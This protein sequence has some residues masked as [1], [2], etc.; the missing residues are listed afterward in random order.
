MSASVVSLAGAARDK[1]LLGATITW[2]PSQIE[3]LESLDGPAQLHLWAIARQTGKSS[4]AGAAA[5]ANAA[6]REDLD[7]MLPHGK[8]RSVPVIAPSESQ[9]KDF[10]QVCQ[11]L[12]EGSPAF[13][14]YAEVLSDRVLFRIPRVDEHG[15]RWTA[16]CAIRALPASAPSIRGLTAALVICE[17]MAHHGDT[18]GPAD[19]R[20]IWDAI[21]P[22]QVAFG[23]KAKVVGISTP[24]G[25][26][27]LFFELFTAI[28]G[29]LMPHAR[30]VRREIAEMIPDI[31]PVWL[32]ARRAEMGDTAFEQEFLA[33]FVGSG[34]AFF[35]LRGVEFEEAPFRPEDATSWVIGTDAAFHGDRFG[36]VL[37]GES[38]SEPGVFLVGSVAGIEPGERLRSLE[39]R[40]Q[41]EDATLQKVWEIVEPYRI[42][43]LKL[44][45]DQHQSDAISSYF[46][47]LGLPV[48]IINITS[49]IQTAAF[50][51]LRARLV[52]GSLRCWKHPLLLE[53]FR[54]VRVARTAE[55]IVLP[56]FAGGHCDAVSAL[57]L[58]CYSLR[59]GSQR[60][61]AART[62]SRGTVGE[63]YRPGKSGW[64]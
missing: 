62:T 11:A 60:P 27:G 23:S 58:A 10:I 45:G 39:S 49:P 8:W 31:D 33:R 40:R 48:E 44:V 38:A 2:R 22:M 25:E 13:A 51:S 52:D 24:F 32:E 15:H 37:V 42:R 43:P 19:E 26:N 1:R 56:R 30:A 54:R 5:V 47:R 64:I 59:E 4:M 46:G 63:L 20:R 18:G 17:E 41:R 21:T 16:K 61:A 55:S 14:E 35:D 57:A 3:L 50:M 34:G 9:A 7:D 36:V 6:L 53:E 29:G 12:V 28:E